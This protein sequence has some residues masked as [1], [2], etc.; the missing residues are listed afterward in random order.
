MG[1]DAGLRARTRP[2]GT[3]ASGGARRY[4]DPVL[5]FLFA[6]CEVPTYPTVLFTVD[7]DVEVFADS[8][9]DGIHVACSGDERAVSEVTGSRRGA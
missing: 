9:K 1:R 2:R 5:L 7:D 3:V 8:A 6:A 4:P